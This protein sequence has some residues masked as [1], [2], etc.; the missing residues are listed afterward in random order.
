MNHY[1]LLDYTYSLPESLIAQEAVH[2]HHNAKMMVLERLS[3][4]I[5][6]E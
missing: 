5:Q 2:P 3:E 6:D 4:D 1:S